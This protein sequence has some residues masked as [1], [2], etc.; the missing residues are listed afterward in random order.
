[1]KQ[2]AD[3][4]RNVDQVIHYCDSQES[5]GSVKFCVY[6]H[7]ATTSIQLSTYMLSSRSIKKYI[8]SLLQL[9]TFFQPV[10]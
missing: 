3:I 2:H 5:D 1:M 10:I 9:W 7:T 6:N 8:E 4:F